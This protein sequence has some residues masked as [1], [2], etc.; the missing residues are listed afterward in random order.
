LLY[1]D[2]FW[3]NSL[4]LRFL[5]VL[6]RSQSTRMKNFKF[7]SIFLYLIVFSCVSSTKNNNSESQNQPKFAIAIHGGAGT[8]LKSQ[9]SDSLEAAYIEVLSKAV[10]AGH[11]ILSKGGSALDAVGASINILE[12]SPLFNAGKGAVF[13]HDQTN[14]LDA[15]I[16]DGATLNAGAVA[17]VMHIKNPIDLARSVMD[18]SPHVFMYGQGAEAF[19][20][21]QGFALV[22]QDYFYTQSRYDHL[23][24]VKAAE[25][26]HS[27]LL[28][29][30]SPMNNQ[31]E[32]FFDPILKA[33]KYG[34]V[35][36]VA[37]DQNGNL[38]AG[39]STGGMTNKQFGRIGDAPVIGAGTY[40]NNQS[41]AVSATGWGEYFIRGVVAHD[42]SAMMQYGGFDLEQSTSTVIDKKIPELGGDGGVIAMDKHGNISMRFN[43][44]GMYRAQIDSNGALKVG[45]YKS[46]TLLTK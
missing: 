15:S 35:G 30:K 21:D 32:M 29:K 37:L 18:N 12:D 16:M 1:A 38:A 23:M 46:D 28:D 17:G 20:K 26:Q 36:C 6:L 27:L 24:R 41:C 7:F 40:A 19:A 13:T 42:I 43:T 11:D 10:S 31:A 22:E 5:L 9:M 2:I 14:E 45:I 33:S 44:P 39:T 25:E 3:F 8:I 34:T 4:I